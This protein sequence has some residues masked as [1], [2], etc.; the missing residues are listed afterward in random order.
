MSREDVSEMGDRPHALGGWNTSD[1]R[2]ARRLT[3][4]GNHRVF[5]CV[6]SICWLQAVDECV[7][8]MNRG[9]VIAGHE[10][11]DEEGFQQISLLRLVSAVAEARGSRVPQ[12]RRYLLHMPAQR[13]PFTPSR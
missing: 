3:Y 10:Q 1:R 6:S 7:P 8:Q 2:T 12:L 13:A 11:G 9:R 4:R 5:R